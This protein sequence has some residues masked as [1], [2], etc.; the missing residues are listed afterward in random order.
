[1]AMRLQM[2][3]HVAPRA[4]AWIETDGNKTFE[5]NLRSHPV[6]VRGLKLFSESK[7]LGNTVAPRAGAWIET[8]KEYEEE[9]KDGVAPRAGAWIETV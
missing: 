7:V 5:A 3:N 8:K 1:M 4:G 6:R 9:L 2:F